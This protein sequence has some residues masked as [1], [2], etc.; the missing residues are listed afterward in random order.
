[1]PYID[2]PTDAALDPAARAQLDAF[3]EDHGH[4]AAVRAIFAHF[5]AALAALDNQY[6]LIMGYGA[7]DRWVREAVFAVCADARGDNYLAEALF[8]EAVRHGAETERLN[9][10][11]TRTPDTAVADDGVGELIRFSRKM[12]LEPYKSVERD[13]RALY[14][15]GWSDAHLLEVLTVVSLSAYMDIMTLSVH[16]GQA[17]A[18][19][20][21]H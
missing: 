12:A 18:P 3:A 14:E 8:A 5:P 11:L 20:G 2:P 10:F 13:V 7:L 16:L 19:S 15:A 21:H 17:E 9:S 1:M 6:R 4:F